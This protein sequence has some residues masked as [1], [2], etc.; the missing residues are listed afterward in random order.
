ML[1]SQPSTFNLPAFGILLKT[2]W[3]RIIV[4]FYK[5]TGC[6][7]TPT[8]FNEP[9]PPRCQSLRK[10]VSWRLQKKS[11][12]RKLQEILF[13]LFLI[14]FRNTKVFAE[15]SKDLNCL[16]FHRGTK[17]EMLRTSF[18]T[19]QLFYFCFINKPLL[20]NRISLVDSPNQLDPCLLANRYV[21]ITA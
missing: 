9:A 14:I 11:F 18:A 20:P 4:Y 16:I 21:G 15:A 17:A 5:C 6:N 13:Q 10:I 8:S 12:L 1:K 3:S 7:N 2:I 19:F